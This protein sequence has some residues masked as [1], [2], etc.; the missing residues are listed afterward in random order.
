MATVVAK[1][2]KLTRACRH[3]LP[4]FCLRGASASSSAPKDM[5]TTIQTNFCHD[6]MC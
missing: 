2:T 5:H 3:Q 1:N 6:G 4:S